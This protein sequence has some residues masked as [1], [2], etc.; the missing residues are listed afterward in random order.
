MKTGLLTSYW[1]II[2]VC[3]EKRNKRINLLCGEQVY[4]LN[5]KLD[6]A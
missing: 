2:A 6:D 5:D 4:V 3:S 1:E